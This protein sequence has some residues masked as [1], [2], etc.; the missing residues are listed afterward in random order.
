MSWRLVPE[1][2]TKEML[3]ALANALDVGYLEALDGGPKIVFNP[4]A[5]WKAAVAARPK[6]LKER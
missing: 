6:R 5:A 2:P 3:D 1:E 4:R